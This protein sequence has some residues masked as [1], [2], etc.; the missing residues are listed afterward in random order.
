MIHLGGIVGDIR[1]DVIF[2]GDAIFSVKSLDQEQESHWALTLTKPVPEA[3]EFLPLRNN[4]LPISEEVQPSDSVAFLHDVV[5][6]ID[7]RSCLA[8]TIRKILA[9]IKDTLNDQFLRQIYRRYIV[10]LYF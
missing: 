8:S 10:N 9:E 7:R 3:F 1:D 5:F 4:F 6:H 2:S